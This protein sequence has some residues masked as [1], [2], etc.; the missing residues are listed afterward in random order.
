LQ[1]RDAGV[2]EEHGDDSDGAKSVECRLVRQFSTAV[3]R[4]TGAGHELL[5]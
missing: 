4:T 1:P 3:A 5:A 2:K